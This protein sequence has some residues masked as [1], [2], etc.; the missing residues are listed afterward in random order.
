MGNSIKINALLNTAR[1]GMSVIFPL[2]TFPYVSRILGNIEFGRYSFSASIISYFLLIS[3]FGINIYAVREGSRIRNNRQKIEKLVSD[4]FT[5]NIFTTLIAM[6][7]LILLV[8]LNGKVYDYRE[9]ICI[10]SLSIIL[11]AVGVDW[12]NTIYEDYLYITI[13]YVVI[14]VI[15]LIAIILFVD[16]PQDVSMYCMILTLA[17]YGG[18]IVNLI[19]VR[20]YIKLKVNFQLNIKRYFS[21]LFILFINSLATVIYVNSD[22]TMLGL[23]MSDSEVGVYSFSSKIY[24]MIK[25]LINAALMVTV[26]R[27]AYILAKDNVNYKKSLA[28][29]TNVMIMLIFPCTTMIFLL[30]KSIIIVVGGNEYLEGVYTLQIL[31]VSL[32]FA[33]LASITSNCILILNRKEKRCL[34]GTTTSAI[35]NVALNVLLIPIIGIEAAAITTVLAEFI[36]M[37]IQIFFVRKDLKMKL[38]MDKIILLFTLMIVFVVV[39]AFMFFKTVIYGDTFV[40]SLEMI[41][42]V[43]LTSVCTFFLLF[44]LFKN[45]LMLIISGEMIQERKV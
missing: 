30:S 35:C 14:Q 13:R 24:N 6:T 12:I 16:S 15:A 7:L 42:G 23:Y 9:L 36:N 25:Y 4:L 11:T 3:T 19:Y 45:K 8:L 41:I 17:S 29:V 39:A 44:Y 33:L 10:Q 40:N 27:L 38:Y 5:I 31:S 28:R 20:K 32:I 26:P 22:I 18:N 34:V 21:P 1:Q 43:F 2:V 37:N